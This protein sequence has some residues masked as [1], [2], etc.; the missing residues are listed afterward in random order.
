VSDRISVKSF[1]HTYDVR[2]END[3]A[4][5]LTDHYRGG[6]VIVA[7]ATVRKLYASR[8]D[9]ILASARHLVLEPSEETKSYQGLTPV[10][11]QLIE[12]GFRKNNRLIAVGGGITQDVVAFAAS[13]LFR[14]VDWIFYPTTLLAQADSCIGSKTSI[15][16]GKYKNQLGGFYPPKEI[17]IDLA[18]LDTLSEI[19]FRSGMGEMLHYYLV[20]GEEDFERMRAEYDRAFHDKSVLRGLIHHSLEFKR[21]YVERDEFDQGPRNVFNYGHSFG[22]AI[23][24]LTKYRVPHGIAVSFGMDIANTVSAKLG[25]IDV[26]LRDRMRALLRKN[27]GDMKLNDVAVDDLI[28]ALRKDKK[29]VGTQ[30]RVVLT[31]G[32]GKMFLTP[33]DI[34]GDVRGTLEECLATYG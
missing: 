21:G 5:A 10:I 27:W 31:K 1:K 4:A 15:N 24:S 17:V 6:D 26:P 34:S 11:S 30:I 16:F 25:Y 2:F 19:D 23:E 32:L 12:M 18:F 28:V 3:F 29:A 13:I 8:L 20:S 14:G 9:P 7:D 33:L 22:H